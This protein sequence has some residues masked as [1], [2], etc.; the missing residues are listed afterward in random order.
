MGELII[1]EHKN[2]ITLIKTD[3]YIFIFS[4][5]VDVNSFPDAWT[6]A[7]EKPKKRSPEPFWTK[8][9][10]NKKGKRGRYL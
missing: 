4:K 9:G 8:R 10:R 3:N 2:F 5:P 6:D 1:L 7:I